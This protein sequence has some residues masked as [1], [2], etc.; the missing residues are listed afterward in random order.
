MAI[1]R[2]D[3]KMDE[4]LEQL[5]G[6]NFLKGET[7]SIEKT[8]NEIATKLA[9]RGDIKELM[10][11]SRVSFNERRAYSILYALNEV[12]MLR[13]TTIRNYL[14]ASL[15]LSNSEKGKSREEVLEMGK[16]SMQ[17]V[18]LSLLARVKGKF[19]WD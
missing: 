19:G 10:Q 17:Q 12:P 16:A 18:P 5:F 6:Q 15:S 1:N 8:L 11:M 4:D 9:F 7:D 14:F 2:G 13:T 3:D